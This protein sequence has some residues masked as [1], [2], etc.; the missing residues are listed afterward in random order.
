MSAVACNEMTSFSTNQALKRTWKQ[1]CL[2][3]CLCLPVHSYAEQS[4]C[5]DDQDSEVCTPVNELQI[6]V[7]LGI[8]TTTNPLYQS[9][10]TPLYLV[11][12]V[13]WYG[14]NWY[15]DNTEIGYQWQN[16]DDFAMETFVSINGERGNF[17]RGFATNVFL[18]E[19]SPGDSLTSD[20]LPSV[21]EVPA[22][23]E[24]SNES[25][26]FA[27]NIGVDDVADRDW[28]I[29][30][31]VRFHWYQKDSEW[32]LSIFQD[33]SGVHKGQQA[34]VTYRHKYHLADW[35]ISPAFSL[36]WKSAN[37]LDYY[38]G[39]DVTDDVSENLF[40]DAKAGFFPSVRVSV[41]RKLNE[42]WQWLIFGKYTHLD[43]GMT[44]SPLVEESERMTFFTGVTYRF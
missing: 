12:D 33:I 29:D 44:D 18:P 13:A 27:T 7:A 42:N 39:I 11:P 10:N 32:S 36:T 21:P 19:A 26:Q 17:S 9:E 2:L 1:I 28:A 3:G 15:L 31:G 14:E 34:I 38:Y 8:G 6:T 4:L 37:L 43:K 30:A 22:L 23:D 16:T 24:D 25:A 40:Y 35:M 20:P 5:A 41:R